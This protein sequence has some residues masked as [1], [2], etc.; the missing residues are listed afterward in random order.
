MAGGA[1]LVKLRTVLAGPAQHLLRAEA[2][3]VKRLENGLRHGSEVHQERDEAASLSATSK[4]QVLLEN[5]ISTRRVVTTKLSEEGIIQFLVVWVL[6]NVRH[7]DSAQLMKL[8]TSP[9]FTE[10]R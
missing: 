1:A 6:V 10:C 2:G 4:S 8:G 9:G 7:E 3:E 5:A